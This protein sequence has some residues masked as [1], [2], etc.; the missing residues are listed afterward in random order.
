MAHHTIEFDQECKS[1]KG[2]GL[3]SG[4]AEIG[5]CAVVCRTCKGTGCHHVKIEYDDFEG[6]KIYEGIEHVYEIN[7]GITVG[8]QGRWKFLD[9]GGMSYTD[10]LSG[11]PFIPGMENRMFICPAWWYQLADYSKKP[12]WDE[13]YESLGGRF[14]DCPHFKNKDICWKRWDIEFGGK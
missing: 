11:K 4:M 5:G 1:C 14:S 10:W 2:T 3:Y 8:S 6:R 7:P 9:F 13:C 12:N